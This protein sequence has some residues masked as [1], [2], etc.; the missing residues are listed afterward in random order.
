MDSMNMRD[1]IIWHGYW[2]LFARHAD[3]TLSFICRGRTDDLP[4]GRVEAADAGRKAGQ[5]ALA[6]MAA[7]PCDHVVAA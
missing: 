7:R 4:G 6:A 3:Q 1:R 2:Q 5:A